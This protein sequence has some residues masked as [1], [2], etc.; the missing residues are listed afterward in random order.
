MVSTGQI[1]AT[2]TP[3]KQGVA[4]DTGFTFGMVKY[5]MPRGVSRHPDDF[6]VCLTKGDLIP[7]F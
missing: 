6:Q 1:C 4:T 7:F 3:L 2:N 5:H